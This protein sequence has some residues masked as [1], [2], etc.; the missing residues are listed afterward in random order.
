[1]LTA[2][3]APIIVGLEV[4]LVMIGVAYYEHNIPYEIIWPIIERVG[5]PHIGPEPGNAMD[6]RPTFQGGS[7]LYNL[8]SRPVLFLTAF[9]ELVI[10]HGIMPMTVAFRV[11]HRSL[12][13]YSIACDTFS[14]FR[15]FSC[16][17]FQSFFPS[18]FLLNVGIKSME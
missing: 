17:D 10:L 8:R 4:K 16:L 5:K 3:H 13:R 6:N 15:I 2:G 1:M 9:V 14:P 18:T 11:I 7:N 12:H